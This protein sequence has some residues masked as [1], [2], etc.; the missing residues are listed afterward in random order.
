MIWISGRCAAATFVIAFPIRTTPELCGLMPASA[1]GNRVLARQD[2]EQI[3]VLP[4]RAKAFGLQSN[5]D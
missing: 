2:L 3:V 4:P 1:Q 5:F